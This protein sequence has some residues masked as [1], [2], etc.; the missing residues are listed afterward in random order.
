MNTNLNPDNLGLSDIQ[1]PDEV[2]GQGTGGGGSGGK[3]KRRRR[4]GAVH[5]PDVRRKMLVKRQDSSGGDS[6]DE[7]DRTVN[8][9]LVSLVPLLGSE[10]KKVRM[11]VR[12]YMIMLSEAM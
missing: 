1:G 2:E 12:T 6:S 3:K 9:N 11:Y 4:R 10:C 8:R 7:T 5:V